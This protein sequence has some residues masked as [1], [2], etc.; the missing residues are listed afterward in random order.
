MGV[1]DNKNRCYHIFRNLYECV[2]FIKKADN[3]LKINGYEHF[4]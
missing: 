3:K 4:L 1:A 2:N